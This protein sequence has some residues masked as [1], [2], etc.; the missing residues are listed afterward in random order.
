MQAFGDMWHCHAVQRSDAGRKGPVLWASAVGQHMQGSEAPGSQAAGS[1]L[2]VPR[3]G[4]VQ[5]HVVA[6]EARVLDWVH[7]L[8]VHQRR[9]VAL[10]LELLKV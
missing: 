2:L 7:Q 3:A 8:L 5:Q 9:Q 4:V 6:R 1:L 10:K